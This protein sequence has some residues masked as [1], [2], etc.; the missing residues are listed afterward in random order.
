MHWSRLYRILRCAR[1]NWVVF[2]VFRSCS[3]LHTHG[4]TY[5]DKN[6]QLLDGD[7]DHGNDVLP[8]LYGVSALLPFAFR[9]WK[10][11]PTGGGKP[12]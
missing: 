1:C 6:L 3:R 11:P 2:V 7:K 9:N 12:F 5:A 8:L 10:D 4:V